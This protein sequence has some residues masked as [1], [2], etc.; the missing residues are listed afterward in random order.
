MR[1]DFREERKW[2]IALA[3]NLSTA[4]LEWHKAGS[5]EERVRR[6]ICVLWKRPR[7]E[8]VDDEND[9]GVEQMGLDDS[10]E[11]Q[12]IPNPMVDYNSSENEDDEGEPERKDITD[13]LDLSVAVQEALD[14][15]DRPISDDGG[16]R[17]TGEQNQVEP[18]VEERDDFSALRDA[19]P[20]DT[21]DV[22]GTEDSQLNL[23]GEDN[24]PKSGEDSGPSVPPG[25]KS[26]STDPLLTATPSLQSASA[27]AT[28]T[29][30]TPPKPNVYFPMRERIAYSDD[31]KLFIDLDDYDG[32]VKDL[33]AL[34]TGDNVIDAPPPPPDLSAIF[35]DLQPFGLLSV[36]PLPT[37]GPPTDTKKKPDRKSDRD[38]PNK[39]VEDTSYTKLVPLGEFMHC[40]PTLVG[41]LNPAKRWRKGKW[42]NHEDAANS[43]ENDAS[44]ANEA[45]CG[46]SLA[47]C[48][49]EFNFIIYQIYLEEPGPHQHL[50][51]L[52]HLKSL[53]M[54]EGESRINSGLRAM[55]CF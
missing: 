47:S 4:V 43:G 32:L 52:F 7:N 39:R 42:L 45:L 28:S 14:S 17:Q 6:R 49:Y 38:D 30:K 51:E 2:K 10:A 27:E 46:M 53:E 16:Q 20:N 5:L 12:V 31:N 19:A 9:K 55:I 22:D 11:D 34:S 15:V 44:A 26:T 50:K 40:K 24:T 21:M 1:T 36:P 25:L 23:N 3:Y 54:H 35:P 48:I 29:L 13:P 33:A 41:P 37:T 8:E 18:K